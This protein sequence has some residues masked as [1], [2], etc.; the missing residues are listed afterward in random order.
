MMASTCG[1]DVWKCSYQEAGGEFATITGA[2]M[3]LQQCVNNWD[4]LQAVEQS[5]AT[6][7]IHACYTNYFISDIV[8]VPNAFFGSGLGSIVMDNVYCIGNE[9]KL[10]Q[11]DYMSVHNC[12]EDDDAGVRCIPST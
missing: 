6:L 7:V 12:K 11:C 4:F 2:K 5:S 9:S 1:K 3:M 10:L 8:A